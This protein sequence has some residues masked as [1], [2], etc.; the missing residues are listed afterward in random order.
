MAMPKI[1]TTA[2]LPPRQAEAYAKG[3]MPRPAGLSTAATEGSPLGP[4]APRGDRAEIS[5][6]ARELVDLRAAVDAGLAALDEVPDVRADR[7]A[8][9][10][11]RVASG[12]YQSAEVQLKTAGRLKGVLENL[13]A[14]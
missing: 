14:L 3:P 6:G 7:V 13:D 9:A 4:H 12:Y 2:S 10:R 1:D 8:A 5:P 11:E